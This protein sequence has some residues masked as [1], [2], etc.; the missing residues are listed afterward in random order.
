MDWGLEAVHGTCVLANTSCT[1]SSLWVSSPILLTSWRK[2]EL[3]L[4]VL[5][6]FLLLQTSCLHR[7][8]VLSTMLV[9]A[10]RRW[11]KRNSTRR[12]NASGAVVQLSR[13]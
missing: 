12:A 8:A 13:C 11:W 10:R 7:W 5:M 1:A 4:S 9:A 2:P 6:L 3:T